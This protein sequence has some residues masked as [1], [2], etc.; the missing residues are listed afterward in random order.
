M[1]GRASSLQRA[2]FSTWSLCDSITTGKAWR[3]H[4]FAFERDQIAVRA[5]TQNLKTVQREMMRFPSR[6]DTRSLA[7]LRYR[8]PACLERNCLV[9]PTMCFQS[10]IIDKGLLPSLGLLLNSIFDQ[11]VFLSNHCHTRRPDSEIYP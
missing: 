9:L 5:V 10:R 11:K 7:I 4:H 2:E 8:K 6:D 1:V 3:T